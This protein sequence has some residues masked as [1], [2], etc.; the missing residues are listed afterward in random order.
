[1]ARQRDGGDA[2]AEALH[3]HG[4]RTLFTLCGGHISPVLIGAKRRGLRIVDCRHEATAVFAADATARLTGTPGVAAVT[5]GPGVTNALTALHNARLAQ[6]PVVLLGGAAPTVLQGRGA[7]QDIDQLAVVR[8]HVKWATSVRRVRDLG[9]RLSEALHAARHGVPG[10]VFVEL[11]LDV[12]YPEA[13]VRE[14]YLAKPGK[15]MRGQVVDA[16]LRRKLDHIFAPGAQLPGPR[17]VAA[18]APKPREVAAIARALDAAER[19]LLLVGSQAVLDAPRVDAVAR[20]VQALGVPVYLSGMARGLLGAADPVQLRHQRR[21]A[22][23]EADVVLLAGVPADFRLDYGRHLKGRVL[24]V[25][26]SPR[27]LRLNRRPH[28]AALADPGRFLQDLAAKSAPRPR[29]AWLATLRARDAA[30]EA[31]IDR[32]AAVPGRDGL[33]PLALFR[34]LDPRLDA[35]S[36]LVGDGGDFLGTASYMLRPRAPLS[37]LDPGVF[38]TLGVGAGFALGAKAARPDAETWILWGDGASAYGLAEVDTMVRCGLPAIGIIGTDA[39][40]GQI[41]RDQVAMLG[42]DVGTVL[43]RSDYQEVARAFGGQGRRVATLEEFTSA[44]KEAREAVAQGTPFLINA[45][46]ARSDFRQG[47]I[48]L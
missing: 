46:L 11:P 17:P 14:W 25:N 18:M 43:G 24:A 7:L 38:G 3:Q 44:V 4:V 19:P 47:S 41:A 35:L 39:S 29:D 1:M 36:V 13:M 27:D 10:P 28:R 5:A 21:E 23:R 40:W 15:G 16:Y 6:S 33:N 37:W 9:A 26:R 34:A 8:P 32:Q 20:A 45:I 48:S 2:V 12:L 31:D 22:L 30:R 42:D